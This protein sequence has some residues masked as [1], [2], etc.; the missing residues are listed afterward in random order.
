[1]SV[2][3]VRARAAKRAVDVASPLMCMSVAGA[4]HAVLVTVVLVTKCRAAVLQCFEPCAHCKIGQPMV[5]SR[6]EAVTG[7]ML[8]N[9]DASASAMSAFVWHECSGGAE[10]WPSSSIAA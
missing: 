10:R 7:R 3:W 5:L 6:A 4:Q 9:E 1:M 8:S 2:S